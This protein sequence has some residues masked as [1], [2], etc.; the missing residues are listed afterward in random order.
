M[1]RFTKSSSGQTG[2]SADGPDTKVDLPA[3]GTDFAIPMFVFEGAED[4]VA[5]AGP[6]KAYV[7]SMVAP[8]KQFVAIA[9][10]GHTAMYTR[11]DAFLSN[12]RTCS[13]LVL[14]C[15]TMSARLDS[16]LV[17]SLLI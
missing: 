7:D 17:R 15:R 16:A 9:D 5:P 14:D 2:V 1:W 4:D 12:C 3:L 10:A 8:Q 13:F 6:A 11:S